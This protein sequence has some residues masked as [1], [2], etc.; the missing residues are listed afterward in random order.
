[1]IGEFE[2]V[3]DSPVAFSPEEPEH[4]SQAPRP[5]KVRECD[6]ESTS[7]SRVEGF[8]RPKAARTASPL[9][10]EERIRT[11]QYFVR[12]LVKIARA[13]RQQNPFPEA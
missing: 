2:T 8:R 10:I 13:K 9:K 12:I 1:M 6:A 11:H 4:T 7:I 5:K 3:Y